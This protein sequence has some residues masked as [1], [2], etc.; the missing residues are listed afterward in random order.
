MWF[1]RDSQPD[2]RN[3]R[4]VIS[5]EGNFLRTIKL[6][7]FCTATNRTVDWVFQGP[8][9]SVGERSNKRY[10][11]SEWTAY[12]FNDDDVVRPFGIFTARRATNL[13]SP[14]MLTR[15]VQEKNSLAW[16]AAS[17]SFWVPVKRLE[18]QTAATNKKLWMSCSFRR[19]A[20]TVTVVWNSAM[21][22]QIVE[23]TR[24]ASRDHRS[25]TDSSQLRTSWLLQALLW[26]CRHGLVGTKKFRLV[27]EK[28]FD[29]EYFLILWK[30]ILSK[31]LARTMSTGKYQNWKSSLP[32]NSAGLYSVFID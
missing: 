3:N 6:R 20:L 7:A 27:V 11:S 28:L 12:K 14:N 24:R 4:L 22:L 26:S 10:F 8:D 18:I 13:N 23:E 17:V 21:H 32:W 25:V 30:K 19:R 1:T 15:P 9:S 2:S 31:K 5:K 16:A 29:L